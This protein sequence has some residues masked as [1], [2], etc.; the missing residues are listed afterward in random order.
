LLFV[1]RPR[2]R[3]DKTC[4]PLRNSTHFKL[5]EKLPV[6]IVC[7]LCSIMEKQLRSTLDTGICATASG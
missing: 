1:G 7:I 6:T 5:I 2:D 3:S 4:H